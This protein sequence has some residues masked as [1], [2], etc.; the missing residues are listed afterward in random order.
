M[1]S[2]A[3]KSASDHHPSE[4]DKLEGDVSEE[5][6]EI[7]TPRQNLTYQGHIITK[8]EGDIIL[9]A[10]IDNMMKSNLEEVDPP[11][12]GS[13]SI[14]RDEPFWREKTF[15]ITTI[16]AMLKEQKEIQEKLYLKQTPLLLLM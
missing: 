3:K 16:K 2:K 14:V 4:D 1:K 7:Q 8:V 6:E 5:A 13:V 9:R 11:V 15:N 12:K 10:K